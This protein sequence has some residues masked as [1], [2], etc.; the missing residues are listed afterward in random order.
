MSTSK[1]VLLTVLSVVLFV[2]LC[3]GGWFGYW[4]LAKS[5]QTRRYEVNTQ[6]Q[7]YQGGLVSQE[8]DRV[9]AYDELGP[10][11]ASTTDPSI[12][13][14]DEAQQDQIKT[15]LCEVFVDLNPAPSDLA[16]ANARICG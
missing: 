1:I 13:S 16:Q 6:S 9:A 7:Q 11:I 12:K 2:G 15:T 10:V 5:S 4:S 3:V 8:R 14:V